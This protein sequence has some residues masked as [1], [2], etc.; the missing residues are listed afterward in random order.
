MLLALTGCAIYYLCCRI[1]LAV[2]VRVICLRSNN[3]PLCQLW[4]LTASSQFLFSCLFITLSDCPLDCTIFRF[5][6][7]RSR[8]AYFNPIYILAC[9][10]QY[11][12]QSAMSSHL[13]EATQRR[14]GQADKEQFISPTTAKPRDKQRLVLPVIVLILVAVSYLS[15]TSLSAICVSLFGAPLQA[16][17][18]SNSSPEDKNDDNDDDEYNFSGFASPYATYDIWGSPIQAFHDAF[19]RLDAGYVPKHTYE[20]YGLQPPKPVK[21]Y[22]LAYD[23]VA[24]WQDDGVWIKKLSPVEMLFLGVDRFQDVERA[25]D[26]ADED[27]FC[28]RLRLHGASF[29]TLP[30]TWPE[31][32]LWCSTVECMQP[33]RKTNFEACFPTAGAGGGVWLLNSTNEDADDAEMPPRF[34]DNVA[35]KN[36]LTMDERCDAIKGLGG[37]FC[38]DV[39]ACEEMDRLLAV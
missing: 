30:V 18:D 31:R 1:A 5:Q 10:A 20:A 23:K 11:L 32:H 34:A 8:F 35:L 19:Y 4:R 38:Q 6:S 25:A 27:D 29:W 28:A 3:A 9:K 14:R 21:R 33:A 2:A 22:D 17:F 39:K 12:A 15:Y 7:L 36:A 37:V 26:Q 16:M 24:C 13:D